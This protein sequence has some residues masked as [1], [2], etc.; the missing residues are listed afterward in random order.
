MEGKKGPPHVSAPRKKVR[1]RWS[2]K[3]L[4]VVQVGKQS[5]HH[6]SHGVGRAAAV[7]KNDRENM[8]SQPSRDGPM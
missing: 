1:K 7:G 2:G 6:S 3:D 5:K 8:V 4:E